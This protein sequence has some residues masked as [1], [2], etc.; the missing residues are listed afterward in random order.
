[1]ITVLICRLYSGSHVRFPHQSCLSDILLLMVGLPWETWARL[2]V[3][4]LI[5]LVVYFTYGRNHSVLRKE[6]AP[7]SLRQ[8]L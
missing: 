1:M 2:I 7:K 3:W 6:G 8:E 4:L 5:G